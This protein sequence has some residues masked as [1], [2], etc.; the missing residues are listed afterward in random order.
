LTSNLVVVGAGALQVWVEA[1]AGDVDLQATVSEVRPDG[2][3][4]YVQ[5][6]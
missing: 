5:S 3:E 6:G 2:L 1:S 4:T